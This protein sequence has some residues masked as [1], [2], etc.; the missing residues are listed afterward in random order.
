VKCLLQLM[1]LGLAATMLAA[2]SSEPQPLL[3]VGSNRWPG[4]EPMFLASN[5]GFYNKTEI[6]LVELPS[7]TDSLHLLYTGEID[8]AALTLDEALVAIE[9]GTKLSIVLIFDISNGADVLIAAPNIKKLQD[10]KGKR[11]GVESTAV[12]SIMLQSLLKHAKLDEFDIDIVY[13]TADEHVSAYRNGQVDAI[14]TFEPSKTQLLK[15][16][17]HELFTSQMIPGLIVD[18]LAVRTEL[19]NKQHTNIQ[20][21]VDG[22]YKARQYMLTHEEDAMQRMAPRLGITANEFQLTF[23]GLKLPSL[24]AN[25][26]SFAGQPSS[27]EKSAYSVMT[28]LLHAGSISHAVDLTHLVDSTFVESSQP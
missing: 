27:F 14:I 28:T 2:C 5:L 24:A 9:Q 4:Y 8:A 1:F 7:A 6:K 13:L 10:I 15:Q 11:V 16:G 17:A 26:S 20:S 19:L 23:S 25:Q 21:L 12:G 3:K 22:Y 18:V